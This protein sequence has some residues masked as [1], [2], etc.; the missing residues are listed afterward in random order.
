MTDLEAHPCACLKCPSRIQ[1]QDHSILQFADSLRLGYL[2]HLLQRVAQQIKYTIT[3][4]LI[5][6]QL[7]AAMVLMAR[8]TSSSLGPFRSV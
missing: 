3:F 2:D 4:R 1:E 6:I 8:W 5:T 7:P